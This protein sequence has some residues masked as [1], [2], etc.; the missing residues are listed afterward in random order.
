MLAR[1][2]GYLEQLFQ[3]RRRVDSLRDFRA[4]PQIPT[5]NVWLTVFLMFVLRLGSFNAVEQQLRRPRRWERWV[6]T[7]KPSADTLARTLSCFS[8][9]ELRE[10]IAEVC[11]SCW[12]RKAI[13][14]RPGDAYRVVALDGHEL[15]SSRSRCCAACLKRTITTAAGDQIEY[16]HRVVTAQWVGVSPAAI[17]DFE[18]VRP[19]EGEVVAAR[20]LFARIVEQF[21]RLIDVITVDALYLEAPFIR[22]ILDAGKH[23]VVVMKQEARELYHDADRLRALV[24]PEVVS[25]GDRTIRL[26]DLPELTSFTTLARPVRVIWSIE[27]WTS[28]HKVAGKLVERLEQ[29]QWVWVTDLAPTQAPASRIRR[30]GHDRWDIEN[31]AFN[32]LSALW[33]MNHY[34]VHTPVAIETLLLTLGLAFLVTYLFFERNLKP[35]LR[36]HQSRTSLVTLL[37][38]DLAYETTG[39]IWPAPFG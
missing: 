22:E 5:G 29:S 2:A 4:R 11:R 7:R 6:G 14:A 9:T 33:H 34:Y 19:G 15:N 36:R 24:D 12:R 20:R 39:S 30:W 25:D 23:I 27:Q 16:Y 37:I 1:L 13:H 21:P 10:L 17:V 31:R 3:F 38:E 26:W 32:E 35:Q 18:L 8:Q 28:H